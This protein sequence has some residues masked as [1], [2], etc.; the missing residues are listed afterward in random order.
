MDV[1]RLWQLIESARTRA[2]SNQAP[3]IA[4][5]FVDVLADLTPDQVADADVA[6]ARVVGTAYSWSLWGA[7]YVANGG[8]SDDGFYYFRGWLLTRGQA[9]WR[10]VLADP[11]SLADHVDADDL[12]DLESEDMVGAPWEAHARLT[13][14]E[15]LPDRD[16]PDE[17]ELGEGWDFDDEAEMT[18]RYP[19]LT[20][21]ADE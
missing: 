8:C 12:G 5:A 18:R 21:L 11:D 13:L 10:A 9:V 1:D 3:E 2:G 7:A 14:L 17:P 15:A 16:Y 4:E 20:A 6:L 19:R